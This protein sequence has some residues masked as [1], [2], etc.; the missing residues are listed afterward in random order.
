MCSTCKG[1]LYASGH[2]SFHILGM[3]F[4]MN[5]V[6][7]NAWTEGRIQWSSCQI[8]STSTREL[9]SLSQI[10]HLNWHQNLAFP[11]DFA[12]RGFSGTT[13]VVEEL[14]AYW[15]LEDADDL[16]EEL[17]EVLIVS[18]FSSP[19][20]IC[21]CV[22]WCKDKWLCK[23]Y[24]LLVQGDLWERILPF[25][26]ITSI[27]KCSAGLGLWP[28]DF[29]EDCRQHKRRSSQWQSQDPSRNQIQAQ[30]QHHFC[31]T[32]SWEK[33]RATAWQQTDWRNFRSGSQWRR[34]DNYYWKTSTQIQTTGCQGEGT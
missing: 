30:K 34:Q 25:S 7:V 33:L 2:M 13:Q 20:S 4:H 21:T 31:L 16:L 27:Q 14:L 24:A 5:K 18:F 15:K 11:L 23:I 6:H 32:T 9:Y 12:L 22:T 8:I 17:E 29:T 19:A 10:L 26:T 3:L 28:Q 1:C